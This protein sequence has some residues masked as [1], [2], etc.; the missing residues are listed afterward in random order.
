MRYFSGSQGSMSLGDV[1]IPT[2]SWSA[3]VKL[4]KKI[5]SEIK[6]SFHIS[7]DQVGR[8]LFFNSKAVLVKLNLTDESFSW[9][10]L[11]FIRPHKLQRNRGNIGFHFSEKAWPNE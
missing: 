3:S 10:G 4:S 7:E 6:G 1:V 9:S 11:V 2:I 5:V 8:A